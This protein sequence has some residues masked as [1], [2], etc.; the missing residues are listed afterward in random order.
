MEGYNI[1]KGIYKTEEKEYDYEIHYKY[2][3]KDNKNTLYKRVM[4]VSNGENPRQKAEMLKRSGFDI[5]ISGNDIYLKCAKKECEKPGSK[6]K[7]SKNK[8]LNPIAK[9]FFFAWILR[10]ILFIPEYYPVIPFF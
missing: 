1:F 4:Q 8:I 9:Y 2:F 10:L 5:E 6:P 7:F 3:I